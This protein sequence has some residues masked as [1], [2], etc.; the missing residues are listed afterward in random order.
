MTTALRPSQ[1]LHLILLGVHDVAASSKFYES[2]GWAKSPTSNDG[3]VKF[4]LGGYALCLLSRAAFASD[5]M[6]PTPQGSGFAGIGLVYLAR[7]ADDVPRILEQAVAAGGTLIKPA[8]KTDWG[9]AGYFKDPDGHLFE[10]DYEDGWLLDAEHRLV[11]DKV[12]P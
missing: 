2:L 3:F 5:A 1:R 11:V 4:D 10:V 9:V 8:T 6:A 7:S 12:N